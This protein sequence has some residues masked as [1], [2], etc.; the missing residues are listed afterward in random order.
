MAEV[1]AAAVKLLRDRTDLPMML[2]K[3][4]L[5]KNDG[6]PDKAMKWLQEQVKGVR[7]KRADNLTAEGR[8]FARVRPD[9]SEGVLIEVQCESAPVATGQNMTEF[10][11][12][13][14]TQLLEGPGAKSPEELLKQPAP[15]AKGKT[16]HDLFDEMTNKI[17]EK[18]VVS[19]IARV[20]GPVGTYVH[21][22][23]KIGVIFRATGENKTAP[24]L[25]DVAMHIAALKP[26]VVNPEDL[27]PA[28][29]KAERDRLSAEA[30]ATGKPD[31]I[32]E[33]IVDG[34]MKVYYKDDAGVLTY[35]MLATDDTKAVSQALAEHGLK[36]KAFDRWV[37]GN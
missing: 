15:G 35:Q 4:A 8:I 19:R 20:E 13:L 27:D 9:G 36:A 17:R 33:K 24:V 25:R 12:Q 11:E 14:L 26:Q 37:I 30:K 21:H 29:V 3:E 1:T 32:I 22:N 5:T 28:K 23:G 31:N 7:E 10:G 16:L 2:C 34:R 18:I 6:D